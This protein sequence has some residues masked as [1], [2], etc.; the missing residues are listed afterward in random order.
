MTSVPRRYRGDTAVL[1]TEL[2][3]PD[4]CVAL[5]DF[6]PVR[7]ELPDLVRIVVGRRGRVRMN[8]E[9]ILRFDYGSVVPWVRGIPGGISAIAGPD[10]LLLRTTVPLRS[11]NFRTHAEFDVAQGEEIAFD[12]T[13]FPSHTEVR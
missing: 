8:M 12:L 9:L 2:T 4:G 10:A 1:E 3:T 6:M 13:W 7:S 11:E 5:I